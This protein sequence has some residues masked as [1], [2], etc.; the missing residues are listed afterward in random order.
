MGVLI[1]LRGALNVEPR[2][3]LRW[4]I[5]RYEGLKSLTK[6]AKMLEKWVTCDLFLGFK[7]FSWWFYGGG[8]R[9]FE[10]RSL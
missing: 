9:V 5:L 10:G 6:K 8:V 2:S 3:E 4:Y 7:C 1:F